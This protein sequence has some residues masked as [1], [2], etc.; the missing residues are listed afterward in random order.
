MA[1]SDFLKETES[2]HNQVI[3]ELKVYCSKNNEVLRNILTSPEASLSDVNESWNVNHE[4]QNDWNEAIQRTGLCEFFVGVPREGNQNQGVQVVKEESLSFQFGQPS[5][6][7]SNGALSPPPQLTLMYSN[8]G[9]VEPSENRNQ[10]VFLYSAQSVNPQV[11][12]SH[13]FN[14]LLNQHNWQFEQ[15]SPPISPETFFSNQDQSPAW[16]PETYLINQVEVKEQVIYQPYQQN[17]LN[18]KSRPSRKTKVPTKFRDL[19]L[20][21][22]TF[23]TIQNGRYD[24][25]FNGTFH[26][27]F[28]EDIMKHAKNGNLLMLVQQLMKQCLEGN[29]SDYTLTGQRQL[30]ETS[31]RCT[32]VKEAAKKFPEELKQN[33]KKFILETQMLINH[34]DLLQIFDAYMNTIF[35]KA[36][37]REQDKERKQR[38]AAAKRARVQNE[39]IYI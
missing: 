31:G 19:K 27:I 32:K 36:F 21:F 35:T 13:N 1:N 38:E 28:Y 22:E 37:N 29:L 20:N 11:Y 7:N 18:S 17:N 33:I 3:D 34:Q 30:K 8:D 9:Q 16:S 2:F 25:N 24:L 4:V 12:Q 14:H 39:S 10:T 15:L 6:V 5:P 23:K 26:T